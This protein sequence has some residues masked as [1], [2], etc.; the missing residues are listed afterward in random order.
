MKKILT[1]TIQLL[2][3]FIMFTGCRPELY[4]LKV[5][6]D[7]NQQ[8]TINENNMSFIINDNNIEIAE[9]SLDSLNW[10]NDVFYIEP[11]SRSLEVKVKESLDASNIKLSANNNEIEFD[12]YDEFNNFYKFNFEANEDINIKITGLSK[13]L[14]RKIPVVLPIST[15]QYTVK[16]NNTIIESSNNNMNFD[17]GEEFE[18]TVSGD[19]LSPHT[20]IVYD[21]IGFTRNNVD[22]ENKIINS[23]NSITFKFI[24]DYRITFMNVVFYDF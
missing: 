6:A 17:Y 21:K 7:E 13:D 12:S 18:V 20:E 4:K 16:V 23:D 15:D 22:E 9:I 10:E 14:I 8:V 19:N 11:G 2:L 1:F 24:A 5:I 3:I